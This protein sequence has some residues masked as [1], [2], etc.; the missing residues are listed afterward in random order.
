MKA[1][2]YIYW[3]KDNKSGWFQKGDVVQIK[4]LKFD[5]T[6]ILLHKSKKVDGGFDENSGEFRLATQSE[7]NGITNNYEIF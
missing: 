4:E 1:G 5:N 3:L 2:D 7:I 6:I